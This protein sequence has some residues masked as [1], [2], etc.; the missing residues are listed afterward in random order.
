M[1]CNPYGVDINPYAI[2]QSK[3]R[4][5]EAIVYQAELEACDFDGKKFDVIVFSDV[6]EHVRRPSDVMAKAE[7]LLK[8]GGRVILLTPDIGSI[9][10]SLMKKRWIHYKREHIFYFTK[11]SM[12]RLLTNCKFKVTEV[13]SFR[14]P[15]T[16]EYAAAQLSHYKLPIVSQLFAL[17]ERALPNRLKKICFQYTYG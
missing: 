9:S 17:L 6:I 8:Q 10:A 1:G 4:V 7:S 14:K 11:E 16:V 5:P 12:K 2:T 13:S 15:V 3:N